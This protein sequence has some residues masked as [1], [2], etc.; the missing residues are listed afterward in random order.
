MH[1]QADIVDRCALCGYVQTYH[2]HAFAW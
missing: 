1:T 2:F